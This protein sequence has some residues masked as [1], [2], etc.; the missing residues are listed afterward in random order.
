MLSM[1][2]LHRKYIK[3]LHLIKICRKAIGKVYGND[4]N[5][6]AKLHFIC[7]RIYPIRRRTINEIYCVYS[8]RDR[9]RKKKKKLLAHKQIFVFIVIICIRFAHIP[10]ENCHIFSLHRIAS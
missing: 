7:D 1:Y 6:R 9:E 5:T 10:I 3:I 8:Q 2:S 4:V